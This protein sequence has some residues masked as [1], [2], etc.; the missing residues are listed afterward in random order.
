MKVLCVILRMNSDRTWMIFTV[1]LPLA[2]DSFGEG[3]KFILADSIYKKL[4][5][6]LLGTIFLERDVHRESL[7]AIA[8]LHL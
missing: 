2:R 4:C 1:P 8:S 7:L 6:G 5:Q 3:H